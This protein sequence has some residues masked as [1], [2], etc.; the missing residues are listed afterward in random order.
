MLGECCIVLMSSQL[1]TA[2]AV[3]FIVLNA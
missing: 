3:W 2:F 1:P